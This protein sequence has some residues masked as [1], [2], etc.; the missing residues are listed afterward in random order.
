MIF[1]ILVK[2]LIVN[3]FTID[4]DMRLIFSVLYDIYIY[5]FFIADGS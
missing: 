5:Y 2:D 1:A 4:N 3:S